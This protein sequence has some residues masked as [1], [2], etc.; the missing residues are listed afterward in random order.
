METIQKSEIMNLEEIKEKAIAEGIYRASQNNFNQASAGYNAKWFKRG[1]IF[2]AELVYKQIDDYAIEFAE[3]CIE[4]EG[5]DYNKY[6]YRNRTELLEI[7]KKEQIGLEFGKWYKYNDSNIIF[8]FRGKYS[9]ANN[10]GAYGFGN[11]GNWY[12]NLGVDSNSEFTELTK[13]EVSK[14]LI[15]EAKKRGYKNGNYKCLS[16]SKTYNISCDLFGFEDNTLYHGIDLRNIVFSNGKWAEIIETITKEE[17]EKLLNK[18]I[19]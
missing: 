10:S 14:A 7:F 18:K 12:E 17:A 4:S 8:N 3:W 15:I 5:K 19:I 11:N 16:N 9:T 2:G 1:A 6:R 13:E